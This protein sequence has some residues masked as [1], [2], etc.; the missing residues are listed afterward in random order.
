MFG[1]SFKNVFQ[2]AL[3]QGDFINSLDSDI[4]NI[5]YINSIVKKYL[6]GEEFGG[7]EMGDLANLATHSTIGVYK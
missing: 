3:R 6:N 5:D 2:N 7:S 1:S 4:F